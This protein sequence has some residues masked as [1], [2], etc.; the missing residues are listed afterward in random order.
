MNTPKII[1]NDQ[2]PSVIADSILEISDAMRRLTSTRLSRRAI[3]AL[4]YDDTKV[5]KRTIELVINSL[6]NL[7]KNWLQ[8]TDPLSKA[9]P[10]S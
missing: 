7:E 4:V 9:F 2:P 3:I 1:L 6:E 10:C 5:S 8:S